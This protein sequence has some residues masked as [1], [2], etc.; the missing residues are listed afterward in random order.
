MK[1]GEG[2]TFGCKLDR[3]RPCSGRTRRNFGPEYIRRRELKCADRCGGVG[4][5]LQGLPMVVE[6]LLNHGYI[7]LEMISWPRLS[8]ARETL[9]QNLFGAEKS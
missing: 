8:F 3:F 6:T 5:S 2:G 9:F 7:K 4:G 1:G